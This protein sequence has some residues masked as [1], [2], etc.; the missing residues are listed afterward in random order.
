MPPLFGGFSL[1]LVVS[2][3]SS[4]FKASSHDHCVMRQITAGKCFPKNLLV[5][6]VRMARDLKEMSRMKDYYVKGVSEAL[7][8]REGGIWGNCQTVVS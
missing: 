8:S 1:V 3:P 6:C 7:A 2:F 4:K 5:S